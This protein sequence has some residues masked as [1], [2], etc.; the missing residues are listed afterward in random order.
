MFGCYCEFITCKGKFTHSFGG[1]RETLSLME[2]E[3][4]TL[5]DFNIVLNVLMVAR[6]MDLTA[7][8]L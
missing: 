3:W 6:F 1:V 4:G 2:L 5:V 8:F 7:M